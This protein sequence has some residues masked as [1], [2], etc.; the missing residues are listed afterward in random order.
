MISRVDYLPVEIIFNL[1]CLYRKR[2]ASTSA[3]RRQALQKRGLRAL[4]EIDPEPP[5]SLPRMSFWVRLCQAASLLD[6]G[7]D[8]YPTMLA[9][10]WLGWAFCD[11]LAWLAAA[12]QKAPA[13]HSKQ[14][15][16]ADMLQ[17]LVHQIP[18][19]PA[20]FP[21]LVGLQAL[22]VCRGERL[23]EL[24]HA[25]LGHTDRR[26][27]TAAQ[28]EPWQIL[29][30]RLSVP[31][32]PDWRL[33]WELE[34]F[35][36]P[37]VA[38]LYRMDAPAVRLAVQRGAYDHSLQLAEILERGLGEP[39]PV[40]LLEAITQQ[41][42]IRLIQG[43]VLEFSHPEELKRLR[44]QPSLRRELD[45]LLSPRHA[46]LDPWRGYQL[47]QKLYRLGLL[48]ET[49]LQD[50]WMDNLPVL[51]AN[52]E[53]SK[54]ERAY[55]LSLLLFAEG[56]QN[57]VAPPPGL[58]PK[59]TGGMEPAL[60]AAATRSATDALSQ[61]CSQ[62]AWVP[63]ETFPPLPPEDL[64]ERLQ[65]AIDR[66][67]AVDVLYQASGRHAPEFRHLRPLLVEQRNGRFYLLAYCQNRR[68]NR[69]FRLDRLKLCAE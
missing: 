28:P 35:F 21:E 7:S 62:S 5:R 63:E 20:Q 45:H 60:R 54:A 37:T 67:E 9:E 64:I 53:L 30:S 46:V 66:A 13:R 19:S 4:P 17:R 44:Q 25:V 23:S 29:G 43:Y 18:L 41:P 2:M 12:W 27:F 1:L 47:L 24:G 8:P 16:R 38:G 68:A 59:L 55:L 22:G 48:A 33:L 36:D 58:V 42:A 65:E 56:L 40:D 51:Q 11:Q 39:P 57:V 61:V 69:T 26:R 34:R 10:E 50:A 52:S 14:N 49:D 15:L 3:A 6:D 31:F 32:P